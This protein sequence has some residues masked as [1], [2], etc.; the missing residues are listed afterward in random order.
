MI[1][2]RAQI[3]EQFS[4]SLRIRHIRV[5]TNTV[6]KTESGFALPRV[7][8]RPAYRAELGARDRVSKVADVS[9]C[10]INSDFVDASE[11][12][13]T[14]GQ[15]FRPIVESIFLTVKRQLPKMFSVPAI[16][17]RGVGKLEKG[18]TI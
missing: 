17:C 10:R 18:S 1:R 2:Q 15:A 8:Q 6:L 5:G 11:R 13:L 16:P 14:M 7:A 12:V 3:R 9:S 4:A